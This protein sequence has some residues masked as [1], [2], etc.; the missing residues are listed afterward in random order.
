MNVDKI[1]IDIK[2]TFVEPISSSRVGQV[3]FCISARTSPKNPLTLFIMDSSSLMT[4][5]A[6]FQIAGAAGIEPAVPVLE[7]G[8]LPINRR[9]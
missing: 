9:S 8:G 6:V 4:P 7:T 5:Q 3:T 1:S 2:T